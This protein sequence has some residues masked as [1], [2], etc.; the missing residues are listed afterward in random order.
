MVV[1]SELTLLVDDF[2]TQQLHRWRYCISER[3]LKIVES[4]CANF[5]KVS[6]GNDVCRSRSFPFSNS[7][8]GPLERAFGLGWRI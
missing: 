4:S 8:S 6:I 7:N 1:A 2:P 3:R 5:R